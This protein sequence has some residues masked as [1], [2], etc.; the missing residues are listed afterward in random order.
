MALKYYPF[1]IENIKKEITT[2]MIK[3]VIQ[4]M[5]KNK[6]FGIQNL[7]KCIWGEDISNEVKTQPI[8][9]FLT[10]DIDEIDWKYESH[11]KKELYKYITQMHSIGKFKSLQSQNP[12]DFTRNLLKI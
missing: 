9:N 12:I 6:K 4:T 8:K 7:L 5:A 1:L 2:L 10:V 11:I 3:S